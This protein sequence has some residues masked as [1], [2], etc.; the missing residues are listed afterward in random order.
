MVGVAQ[1]RNR[2]DNT[3]CEGNVSVCFGWVLGFEVWILS[4]VQYITWLDPLN[5]HT[6]HYKSLHYCRETRLYRCIV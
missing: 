2:V 1:S 5:L 6:L 3:R 4:P